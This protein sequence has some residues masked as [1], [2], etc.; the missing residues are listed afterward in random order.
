MR[1][2][3]R[4]LTHFRRSVFFFFFVRDGSV[5]L[6]LGQ[7]ASIDLYF[8]LWARVCI[9]VFVRAYE[10]DLWFLKAAPK[11]FLVFFVIVPATI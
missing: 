4:V 2:R 5:S 6:C 11:M 7:S 1:T 9:C 3:W 10:C 8:F